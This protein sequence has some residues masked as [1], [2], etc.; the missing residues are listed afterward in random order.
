[1]EIIVPQV[2]ESI[3]EAEIG[4]WFKKDGEQVEKDDLLLDALNIDVRNRD[5]VT[6]GRRGIVFTRPKR[7]FDLFGDLGRN[8]FFFDQVTHHLIKDGG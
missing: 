7:G 8:Q 1:M 2:G 3:V 6:D 5:S 4:A